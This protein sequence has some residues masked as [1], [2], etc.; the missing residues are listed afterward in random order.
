[1]ADADAD[2]DLD[3]DLDL[4]TGSSAGCLGRGEVSA[5]PWVSPRKVTGN[6]GDQEA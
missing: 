3:L 1:V 4:D 6:G 2:A 5:T